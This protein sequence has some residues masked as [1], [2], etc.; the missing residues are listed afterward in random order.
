MSFISIQCVYV[1]YWIGPLR[2]TDLSFKIWFDHKSSKNVHYISTLWS[3]SK[4][5]PPFFFCW[6]S[7]WLGLMMN[8]DYLKRHCL[9]MEIA[10]SR[11]MIDL[12]PLLFCWLCWRTFLSGGVGIKPHCCGRSLWNFKRENKTCFN[13]S[14]S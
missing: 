5:F 10:V 14:Q 4:P 2:S 6:P 7:W 13:R 8:D 1:M 9:M 12:F 3:F 11:T